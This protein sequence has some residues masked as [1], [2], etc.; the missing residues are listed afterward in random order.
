MTLRDRVRELT[1][2][3]TTW[4]T[5]ESVVREVNLLTRGWGHYFAVAHYHRSFR[6][7]DDFIAHR[8]RQ[9]LW[10]KQSKLLNG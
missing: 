8:L 7:L 6:A 2:Q 4:K 1:R 9:W 5:V 10:R 3:C